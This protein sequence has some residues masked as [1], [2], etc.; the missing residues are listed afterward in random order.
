[1]KENAK[2]ESEERNEEDENR[3]SDEEVRTGTRTSS[4]HLN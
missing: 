2:K 4:L 3:E 1:M